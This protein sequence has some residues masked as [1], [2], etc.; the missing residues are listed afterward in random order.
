MFTDIERK[1]SYDTKHRYFTII[2][3]K[4]QKWLNLLS[5]RYFLHNEFKGASHKGNCTKYKLCN[6]TEKNPGPAVHYIDASK[7]IKVKGAI[8]Y[9]GEML[10]SSA[11][12]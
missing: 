11:L 4:C 6:D 8:S 9:L 12:Q 10:G 2:H 3:K 5:S 7:T 1:K